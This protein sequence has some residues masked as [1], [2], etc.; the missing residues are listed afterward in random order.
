MHRRIGY[1]ERTLIHR[2]IQEKIGIREIARRL[3]KAWAGT[4]HGVPGDKEEFW[5]AGLPPETGAVEGGRAC[6]TSWGEASHRG[7]RTRHRGK[8][9]RRVDA[10]S[11][12][13]ESGH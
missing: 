3:Q 4:Q 2:W 6:A 1:T 12:M 11:D 5:R 7:D 10:G 8:A 9:F 13:R